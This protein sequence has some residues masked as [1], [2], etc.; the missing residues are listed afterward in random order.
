MHEA[1]S[2]RS[3]GLV[4]SRLGKL[5]EAEKHGLQALQL[6]KEFDGRHG[7]V[8]T[9]RNLSRVY[10]AMGQVDVAQ[11]MLEEAVS[12]AQKRSPMHRAIIQSDLGI[13]YCRRYKYAAAL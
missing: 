5:A 10:A 3:R 1:A 11:D 6:Y 13:I 8:L 4:L 12:L 2:Y 7:Y 9:L